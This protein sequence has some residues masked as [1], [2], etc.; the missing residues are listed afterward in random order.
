[1]SGISDD[2][3][4]DCILDCVEARGSSGDPDAHR[5]C[6][7]CGGTGLVARDRGLMERCPTC[8]GSGEVPHR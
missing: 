3:L 7:D 5:Q 8:D 2:F 4:R 1:M 6:R